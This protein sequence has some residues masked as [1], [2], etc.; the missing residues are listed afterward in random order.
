M[1]WC[2]G[3]YIDANLFHSFHSSLP[4]INKMFV[5]LIIAFGVWQPQNVRNCLWLHSHESSR[6]K[7]T[8]SKFQLNKLSF[9]WLAAEEKAISSPPNRSSKKQRK[10]INLFFTLNLPKISIHFI[11][12]INYCINKVK[13]LIH[14]IRDESDYAS[15]Y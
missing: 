12:S 7:Q 15:D 1:T 2:V 9:E 11:K 6:L 8:S 3:Q 5:H 10:L 13:I 4:F 14:F